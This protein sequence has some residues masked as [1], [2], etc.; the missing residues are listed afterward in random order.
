MQ[1]GQVV[2]RYEWGYAELRKSTLSY[3]ILKIQRNKYINFLVVFTFLITVAFFYIKQ[4]R[5]EL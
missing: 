3:Q 1:V 5:F 2:C 4:L